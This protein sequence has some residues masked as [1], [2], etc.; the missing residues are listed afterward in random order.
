MKAVQALGGATLC[1]EE[2]VAELRHVLQR[3]HDALA[4]PTA[5]TSF[6]AV[7]THLAEVRA[8]PSE[9][10]ESISRLEQDLDQ[11]QVVR[12]PRPPAEEAA[13]VDEVGL[14]RH[15]Q[16]RVGYRWKGTLRH[17][18]DALVAV[19]RRREGRLPGSLQDA[20]AVF[21][22]TNVS[23]VRAA[24]TFPEFGG[25]GTRCSVAVRVNELA[26]IAWLRQPTAFPD[27]P[28][29]Q[30]LADCAAAMQPEDAVWS[31]ALEYAQELERQGDLSASQVIA[32]RHSQEA[33]RSF[34]RRTGGG[35]KEVNSST[36]LDVMD[37]VERSCQEPVVAELENLRARHAEEGWRRAR[38][39]SEVVERTAQRD[40]AIEER[41]REQQEKNHTRAELS[42][43]QEKLRSRAAERGCHRAQ[44]LRQAVRLLLIVLVLASAFVAT[45][46]T[47]NQSWIG[48]LSP[49]GGVI[50]FFL[51]A[52]A[53]AVPLL[54]NLLPA[55]GKWI[56]SKLKRYAHWIEVKELRRLGVERHKDTAA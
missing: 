3:A 46:A 40:Q 25:A 13:T 37:D 47:L 33:Q 18:L 43:W 32:L 36:I 14:G 56:D 31:K 41:N 44:R 16:E 24:E 38:L 42:S 9:V 49:A 22:T 21:V 28:K 6:G 7:I 17:D 19:H 51:L 15:L 53:F 45:E 27:L 11:L 50:L 20:V 2:T 48:Q 10:M 35:A 26:T 12:A 54:A 1:F 8:S 23:L 29:K 30:V 4:D 5:K 34:M 39:E 55:P 52:V